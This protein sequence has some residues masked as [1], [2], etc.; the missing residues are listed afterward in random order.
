MDNV[1][2]VILSQVPLR[3]ECGLQPRAPT[4]ALPGGRP[5]RN[6]LTGLCGLQLRGEVVRAA[7]FLREVAIPLRGYVVCNQVLR[8]KAPQVRLAVA[9]PLRGYVVCNSTPLRMSFWTALPEGGL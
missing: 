5:C 2:E 4:P 8:E 9:I 1:V 6:P 3:G 7:G